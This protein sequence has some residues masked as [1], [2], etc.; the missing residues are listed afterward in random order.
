MG[1]GDQGR[2][3]ARA[4]WVVA[5]SAGFVL[6]AGCASVDLPDDG[7]TA[8]ATTAPVTTA[9]G[10]A[11]TSQGSVPTDADA[12]TSTSGVGTGGENHEPEAPTPTGT[13]SDDPTDSTQTPGGATD[14]NS[15]RPGDPDDLTTSTGEAT[16]LAALAELKVK[17]RAPRT[18]YDRG[19][20]KYRAVDL[21]RNGCDTRNDILRRDLTGV[22][23]KSGTHGCVVES[24]VLADP[25]S[26]LRIDFT[27]GSATSNDVQIDH[28]VALSDAWQKGAQRWSADTL[29]SFGND[30]LNLLAVDGPLNQQKSDGDAATWLPPNKPFR[31]Q[32]VARQIAVKRAYGLWVTAAEKTTMERIL[33]ACPDEPLPTDDSVVRVIVLGDRPDDAPKPTKK[34][35][36]EDDLDPDYGTCK[37]AIRHGA[38]PYY[39]D[40]DPEYYYYRDGDG[41]GITCERP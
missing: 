20:F 32:Y 10:A 9:P 23:L 13:E 8:P 41:D 38:G 7:T 19:A 5:V 16:A 24:G 22:V 25:Y 21:D 14:D 39:A 31:C 37:E 29:A 1:S 27:R 15:S 12:P 34:P 33:G 36:G 18:G 26:A 35:T 17:G 6:L 30:P 2:R 40:R 11:A 3:R 4:A 28:V